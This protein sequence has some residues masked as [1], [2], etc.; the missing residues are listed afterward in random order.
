MSFSFPSSP[1]HGV[2]L[3]FYFLAKG[4]APVIC[5]RFFKCTRN[6]TNS[7]FGI[8]HGSVMAGA[9]GPCVYNRSC[10]IIVLRDNLSSLITVMA[11]ITSHQHLIS[12]SVCNS[13]K[14]IR[15][16]QRRYTNSR[17][18]CVDVIENRSKNSIRRINTEPLTRACRDT[19]RNRCIACRYG[20]SA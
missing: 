10:G 11:H 3:L 20:R 2:F 1:L 13:G 19:K 6:A 5:T 9:C 17:T 8:G 7:I 16:C 14:T 4:Y 15:N 18:I 12:S